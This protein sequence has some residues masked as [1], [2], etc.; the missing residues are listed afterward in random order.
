MDARKELQHLPG[1]AASMAEVSAGP[2]G[3]GADYPKPKQKY[4]RLRMSINRISNCR[5][6]NRRSPQFEI[7]HFLFDILRFKTN[8]S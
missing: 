8:F 2:M 1:N 6:E 3:S 7:R 5:S 4:L